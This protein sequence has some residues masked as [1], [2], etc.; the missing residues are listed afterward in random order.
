MLDASQNQ[1]E[2]MVGD[3]GNAF[4]TAPC[5]E[6]IWSMAGPEFQHQGRE[7]SKVILKR[8][9]YGLKTAS[10]SFHEF[11]VTHFGG[12]DLLALGQIRIYGSGL[13]MITKVMIT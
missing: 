8:A 12:W 13:R 5:A 3:V 9:L 7:G 2:L 4:P 10:R 1:L 11:L 6:K